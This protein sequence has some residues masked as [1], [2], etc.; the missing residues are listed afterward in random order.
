MLASAAG[1]YMNNALMV[2][3]PGLLQAEYTE[4]AFF[5][6]RLWMAAG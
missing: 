5:F 4:A 6:D 2:S 1:A 3:C